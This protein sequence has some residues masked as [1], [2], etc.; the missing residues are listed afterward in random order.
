MTAANIKQ[1]HSGKFGTALI[2]VHQVMHNI[3]M[4]FPKTH[5]LLL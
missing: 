5:Q 1:I 3:F 2:A 4:T